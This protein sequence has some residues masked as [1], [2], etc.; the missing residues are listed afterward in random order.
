MIIMK[1]GGTSVGS[2]ARIKEVAKLVTAQKGSFVVLSA[3]SGVTN[4]LAEVVGY[5]FNR[6]QD[7][8][9]ETLKRLEAK[10]IA[11]AK[12]LLGDG[13]LDDYIHEAFEAMTALTRDFFGSVQERIIMAQGELLSTKLMEKYLQKQ[14][15]DAMLLPALDFMRLDNQGEPDLPYIQEHLLPMVEKPADVY[16]TQGY[17]CRNAHGEV[18]NLQRGG[19]DYTA[20]LVG[21]ALDA[22][23]IQIWT[24]IDGMHDND[25]R[26]V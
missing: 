3:M 12:E 8:A 2:A 22:E 16:L 17:I 9:K 6:N 4:T 11:V 21:A 18:D 25:P 10:H 7:G 23:E 1:F 20:S 13:S 24:D 26:V 15:V 5:M 19:S 14:G